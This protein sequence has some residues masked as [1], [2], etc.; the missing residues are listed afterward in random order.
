MPLLRNFRIDSTP[1]V[2]LLYYLAPKLV[3]LGSNLIRKAIIISQVVDEN[4]H[5]ETAR[6]LEAAGI[7]FVQP[8]AA[9]GV[10]YNW[11]LVRLVVC[12]RHVNL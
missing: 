12:C 5:D 3:L 7:R 1:F 8:P 4:S 6:Q 2:L 11:N 9:K 10:T